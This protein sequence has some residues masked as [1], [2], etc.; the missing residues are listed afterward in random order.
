MQGS[1]HRAYHEASLMP[2]EM[3]REVLDQVIAGSRTLTPAQVRRLARKHLRD[4]DRAHAEALR[5]QQMLDDLEYCAVLMA[6][7]EG[8]D[9]PDCNQLQEDVDPSS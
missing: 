7:A 8:F 5:L 6:S 2:L 1:V 9:K 4:L 3:T